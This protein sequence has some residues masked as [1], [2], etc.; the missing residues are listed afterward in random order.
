M[1]DYTNPRM[2]PS[3]EFYPDESDGPLQEVWQ[4]QWW[5]E[6]P[7]DLLTP[8][9]CAGTVQFYVNEIAQLD[10]GKFYIPIMWVYCTDAVTGKRKLHCDAYKVG[11]LKRS[12]EHA[13]CDELL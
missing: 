5:L 2:A 4:F 9:Y 11:Y 13:I 6:L 3:L 10:N 12:V 8:M 1:K 7:K